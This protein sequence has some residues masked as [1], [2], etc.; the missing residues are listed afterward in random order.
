MDSFCHVQL[1]SVSSDRDK[2][3]EDAAIDGHGGF[4]LRAA[5]MV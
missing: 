4:E 2:R 1:S 5:N 3:P